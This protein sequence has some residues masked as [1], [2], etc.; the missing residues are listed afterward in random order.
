MSHYSEKRYDDCYDIHNFDQNSL[1]WLVGIQHKTCLKKRNFELASSYP[2]CFAKEEMID[3]LFVGCRWVL[4][5]WHSSF[6]FGCNIIGN[7]LVGL[8]KRLKN[9]WVLGVCKLTPSGIWWSTCKERNCCIFWVRFGVFNISN[10]I[11]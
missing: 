10:S 11:S 1:G 2:M 6:G 3:C 5:L 8:E 9:S 4:E 7:V